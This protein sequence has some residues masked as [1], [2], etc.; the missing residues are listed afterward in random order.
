MCIPGPRVVNR[1]FGLL[2]QLQGTVPSSIRPAVTL[3]T[4]RKHKFLPGEMYPFPA[5]FFHWDKNSATPLFGIGLFIHYLFLREEADHGRYFSFA[6]D[7]NEPVQK[8]HLRHRSRSFVNFPQKFSHRR[9][10]LLF[11]F[12]MVLM[13]SVFEDYEL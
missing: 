10:I 4:A 6:R 5:S 13:G 12:E 1:S 9:K 7:R 8:V 3:G 2:N 11:F